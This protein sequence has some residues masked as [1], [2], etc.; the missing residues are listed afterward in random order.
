[1]KK[2]T[3]FPSHSLS[4][5]SYY[6]VW[7]H[8]LAVAS[9][10]LCQKPTSWKNQGNC[11]MIFFKGWRLWK[12]SERDKRTNGQTHKRARLSWQGNKEEPEILWLHKSQELWVSRSPPTNPVFG[13][14]LRIE[15]GLKKRL[16]WVRFVVGHLSSCSYRRYKLNFKKDLISGFGVRVVTKLRTGNVS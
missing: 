6:S 16:K 12:T 11:H 4:C 14:L 9:R 10:R 8:F 7:E 5:W 13:F 3:H 15:A 1:M 2:E